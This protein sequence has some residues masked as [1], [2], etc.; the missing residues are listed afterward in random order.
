MAYQLVTT[1]ER[2]YYKYATSGL[3]TNPRSSGGGQPI[4]PYLDNFALLGNSSGMGVKASKYYSTNYPWH[5]F[6]GASNTAWASSGGYPTWIAWSFPLPCNMQ[7]VYITNYTANFPRGGSIDY[8]DDGENWTEIKTWTSS[9]GASEEWT[10]SVNGMPY[11]NPYHQYYRLKITSG[12]NNNYVDVRNITVYGTWRS[13]RN[14]TSSNY[15]FYED[16]LKYKC[17]DGKA[18]SI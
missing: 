15:D 16:K 13:T 10:I 5:A 14:G 17:I 12:S 1:T 4:Y 8:S 11:A 18:I 3:N 9:A 7:T 6:D 2:K